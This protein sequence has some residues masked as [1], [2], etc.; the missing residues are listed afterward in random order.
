[1]EMFAVCP[2]SCS[3]IFLF[4]TSNNDLVCSILLSYF[5]ARNVQ[6]I[7]EYKDVYSHFLLYYGSDIPKMKNAEK[8][9]KK[10]ETERERP[11]G[12]EGEEE[13][14]KE[15]EEEGQHDTLKQATRKSGYTLCCQAG[16]GKVLVIS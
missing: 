2:L 14:Q 12:E 4:T 15:E 6:S 10:T 11:E 7:E 16:L 5:R 3:Y 13:K 1:M 8:Q 9:K